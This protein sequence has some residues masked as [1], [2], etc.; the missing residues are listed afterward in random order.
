MGKKGSGK[1]RGGGTKPM[2]K[3]RNKFASA[4]E[5]YYIRNSTGYRGM[6]WGYYYWLIGHVRLPRS[7]RKKKN[8][9]KWMHLLMRKVRPKLHLE[10]YGST[11]ACFIES[12][13]G[14]NKSDERED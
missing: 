8:R 13:P 1:G 11:I 2:R 12:T 14:E 4:Y 6:P 10:H 5:R 7:Y 9:K 3:G